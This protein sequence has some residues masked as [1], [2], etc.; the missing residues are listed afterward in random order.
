M[1][2]SSHYVGKKDVIYSVNFLQVI[3]EICVTNFSESYGKSKL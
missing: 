3:Q 2:I 1:V